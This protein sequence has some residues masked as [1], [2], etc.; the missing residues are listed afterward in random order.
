MLGRL[1]DIFRRQ[2]HAQKG[3][4]ARQRPKLFSDDLPDVIYAI[5][6]IHGCLDLLK[7]LEAIIERDAANEP[8]EKVLITLGD[9]VDRGPYSAAVI[10]HLIGMPRKGW[11]RTIHLAGNH[12][13]VMLDFLDKPALDHKWL[14]FGGK[15]TLLSYGIRQ[16]PETRADM[17]D[18]LRETIPDSHVLFLANLPSLASFPD[19]CFVHGGID[20]SV[21]LTQQRDDVLL[22]KRPGGSTVAAPYLVIHGHTPVEK[23]DIGDGR[24]NID[25]GAYATGLLSAVKIRKSG[26][27][28]VVSCSAS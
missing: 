21:D 11:G 17:M 19:L 13:E 6:D 18:L 7:R 20:T 28:F 14:R 25:T 4:A 26:E 1:R 22:W 2:K 10:E 8:G 9:Y 23:V 27:I 15:E 16:L 24:V 5:G 12:E 3:E